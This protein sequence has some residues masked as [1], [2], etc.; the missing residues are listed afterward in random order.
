MSSAADSIRAR[1]EAF[2]AQLETLIR[3]RA[4]EAV[5][6]ALGGVHA[7]VAA[8]GASAPPKARTLAPRKALAAPAA[9]PAVPAKATAPKG[10]LPKRTL[11]TKGKKRPPGELKALVEKVAS[12]IGAY[13]GAT[14]EAIRDALSTPS[15]EL[16]VP[17][18]KLIAA[19]RI[20]AEGKKQLTRYFPA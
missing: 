10:A 16:A 17:A 5:N 15:A 12:Y 8:P 11:G 4:L 19:G 20:R 13:P 1:I 3:R 2:T 18:R 14:M 6:A 9:S 7:A